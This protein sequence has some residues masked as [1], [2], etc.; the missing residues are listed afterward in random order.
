MAPNLPIQGAK[1]FMNLFGTRAFRESEYVLRATEGKGIR[2][3]YGCLGFGVMSFWAAYIAA[4][5]AAL[6]KKIWWFFGGLF[7]L[8]LINV[9]RLS[10]V[11]QAGVS[12]WHFP[13]GL[14]HHT[15][16]N[17]TA[18]LAIFVMMYFF[19]RSIKIKHDVH[20]G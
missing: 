11:L 14:D 9:A 12:G 18:Y 15:W 10:L 6:S 8:W 17:I 20:D 3:V 19:E 1:L 16:F 4:T 7:L 5:F 2:I 13:L